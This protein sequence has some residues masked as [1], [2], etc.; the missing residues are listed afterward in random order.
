MAETPIRETQE[1]E[2][3]AFLGARTL[4]M[5]RCRRCAYVRH[6]S[7]WICPECLS[8][9]WFWDDLSGRGQIETFI[10]YFQALDPSFSEVPYNVA[11]VKLEEG[12]RVISN[13]IGVSFNELRVDQRVTAVFES[14][15]AGMPLLNFRLMEP[16]A[17]ARD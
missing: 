16:T 2:Y 6:P 11:I 13:I 9:Q 8:E 14:G 7:R 15:P 10:W 5:Q 12:P 4:K 1:A 17:A 3:R